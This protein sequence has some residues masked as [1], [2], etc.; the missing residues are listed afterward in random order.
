MSKSPRPRIPKL[1][2][3]KP[4]PYNPREISD[5]ALE[6]LKTSI[7]E[8]GDISGLVWNSR[9]GHLVAG[10]QR[11]AAL[12]EK[13]GAALKMKAGVLEA[14]GGLRFPVR[15]VDWPEI[16]EKSAN[17]AANS[18]LLA[19]DFTAALGPLLADI[20]PQMG[21]LAASLRFDDIEIPPDPD[22]LPIVDADPQIDQAAELNK[23]WKV[24]RGDLW[25]LGAH[26][27]LCGDCTE[28]DD[29][30]RLVGDVRPLL[31][32]TDPPYGVE[33]DPN[34][35]NEEAKKGNLAYAASRIGKVQGDQRVD[36]SPAWQLFSGDVFYCWHAGR[37]ASEV[38]RSM[39]AATFEIRSQ[40]I[41]A[42]SN[43]PISRGHYH[44]RHEP[45]WYAVRKGAQA[46]WIGDRTQTTLWEVNL[47]KNVEGGHSTQ[48]PLELMAR[49]IRNHDAPE[50]YDPFLGSGTTLIAA[51]N[52]GRI[53]YAM[54]IAPDYCAVTLQRFM[55]ATGKKPKR[56][57]S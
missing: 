55:D 20:M 13:H 18:P 28:K 17:I 40:I 42:K 37:H 24:K 9:T 51:E 4:A 34:W 54:E 11:L 53:C 14:P 3:L 19:G 2:D 27:L 15:V 41:W 25:G 29:V 43:F 23:T 12:R 47:D 50:V 44:W 35:R 22:E 8:F 5:E 16:K 33:Y 57:T 39:E 36:W 48:K 56:I 46:H 49:P 7:S 52:L 45:C 26:R 32:V 6:A 1:G 38:Q 21:D 31:M 10:H 30:G